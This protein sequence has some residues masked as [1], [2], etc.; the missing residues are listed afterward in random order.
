MFSKKL[1]A[2][3][4]VFVLIG[5]AWAQMPQN[6]NYQA[7][8]RDNST[9][10]VSNTKIGMKI[11]ILQ[12]SPEGTVVYSET[13]TPTTNANGLVS[14]DIGAGSVLWWLPRIDDIDWSASPYFLKTETDPDGGVSYS[15]IVINQILSVPYA[16]HTKTAENI[17]GTITETDPLFEASIVS[18]IKETDIVNWNN[19]QN[20]LQAGSGIEISGNVI[21]LE[22]PN[23][24]KIPETPKI[25]FIEML[26]TQPQEN[27]AATIWYDDFSTE[28]KQYMDG[29]GGIDNAV[30]F[31]TKGGA[32]DTGFDKGDVDGNGNRKVAFGDFPGNVRK[33]REGEQ[34]D[35][36]YW[37]IYVKHEHG[38]EGSPAKMSRATSIV[39]SNWR[40]AMIAHVWSGANNSLTLDPARGVDG[41]TDRIKTTKYND[42]DNLFWLGNKPPSEFKISSTEESGYWV[43][44]ESRAKLNTPGERDGV[45]QLWIDGRLET[46]RKNLNFRGSY[47]KHGINAIFL[48]SYWNS[49]SVKTQG[50]WFDN[51]VISTEPIGPVVCPANP[52]LHKTPY[53]GPGGLAAWEVELS[54][55]YNG[56]DVV[57]KSKSLVQ[58]ETLEINQS[59][60][61]FLGTLAGQSALASGETYFCRVRQKS[62]FFVWSNWSRWHQGFKVR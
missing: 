43:L 35:D 56:N 54:S 39:S 41:Q 18:G 7:V 53:Y 26:A 48:E 25:D 22:F 57:F 28:K 9:A 24:Q 21:S 31:G 16:L 2:T 6:I 38:W 27:D 45:N 52:V 49:G 60:G 3:L 59:T 44:V 29:Y 46:E 55:D 17:S 47:T 1:I 20:Q 37:R 19:K 8:V 12:D 30:N 58:V 62:S 14:V 4:F 34:F 50:R 11:S 32:M 15:I 10:L 42:F 40:Q 33:V 23:S 61:S 36:I 13:H 5:N 51:F